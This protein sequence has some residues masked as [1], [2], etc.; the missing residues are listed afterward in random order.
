MIYFCIY[1]FIPIYKT[2]QE[3]NQVGFVKGIQIWQKALLTF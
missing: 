3:K 1:L 2:K